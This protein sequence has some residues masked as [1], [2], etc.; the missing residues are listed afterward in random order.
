MANMH[1]KL[2]VLTLRRVREDDE[3]EDS[4]AGTPESDYAKEVRRDLGS[5]LGERDVP[6]ALT[7]RRVRS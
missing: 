4:K 6:P 2:R 1:E 7:I 5:I 3:E